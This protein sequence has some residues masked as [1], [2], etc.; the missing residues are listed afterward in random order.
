MKPQIT[1]MMLSHDRPNFL[2]VAVAS[3]LAQTIE[4][5]ELIIVDDSLDAE[6]VR[7]RYSFDGR[8]F[9]VSVPLGTDIARKRNVALSL[10]RA[11]IICIADDDDVSEKTRFE[12]TVKSFSL[13]DDLVLF[14]AQADVINSSGVV[15]TT[16]HFEYEIEYCFRG[17]KH[18]HRLHDATV[19]Y[20]VD[21]AFSVGCS[22][23]YWNERGYGKKRVG[24]SQ[25]MG[26]TADLH[27]RLLERFGP[28]RVIRSLETLAHYRL[29]DTNITKLNLDGDLP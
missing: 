7:K 28:S 2:R 27:K 25:R 24:V 20:R 19:A 3:I 1:A 8:I 23:H 14:S 10:A 4:D 22:D 16:E 15:T 5:W 13:I 17:E 9:V 18:T 11:D 6:E 21:A 12:K 26:S 29:H